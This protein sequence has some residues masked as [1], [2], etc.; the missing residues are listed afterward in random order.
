MRLIWPAPMPT[1]AESL[2]YTMVFD[3]TCLATR[4][5]KR[6]SRSSA[7]VGARLVTGLSSMSS[8]TALSRDCTKSPP[9]TVFAVSPLARGSGRPPAISSRKFFFAPDDGDGFL[10]RRRRDDH[11]GENLGDGARGFR[12]ERPVERDNAAEGGDRIA[13]ERLAVGVDEAV[14]FG[15]AARIGVL[16]DGASRGARRIELGDAFVG[17]VGV[18]DVVVGELLAL[19]L[20]RRGDAEPR[21]GRAVERRPLMRILAVAQFLDQAAADGTKIRRAYC[22]ASPANQ[23]AIAVS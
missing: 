13:G 4:K 9:A 19:R 2:A 17:R 15:D 8:T 10:A 6:K 21:L 14:A 16:D 1:V 18:V 22:R 5:A 7:S 23:L 3:F 20:A 11:F 12:I